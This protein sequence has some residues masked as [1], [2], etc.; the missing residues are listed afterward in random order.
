MVL[1]FEMFITKSDQRKRYESKKHKIHNFGQEYISVREN[2]VSYPHATSGR[3]IK[4]RKVS[5]NFLLFACKVISIAELKLLL[6]TGYKKTANIS[7]H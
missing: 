1:P 6:C 5:V 3:P 2:L 7:R 4:S